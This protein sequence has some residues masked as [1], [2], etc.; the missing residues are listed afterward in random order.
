[1]MVTGGL[2]GVTLAAVGNVNLTVYE[3]KDDALLVFA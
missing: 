2:H 3:A 1:M